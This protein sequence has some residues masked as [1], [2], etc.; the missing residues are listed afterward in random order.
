MQEAAAVMTEHLASSKHSLIIV[1][2]KNHVIETWF[3]K[4]L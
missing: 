3:Q 1:K 2:I 4:L